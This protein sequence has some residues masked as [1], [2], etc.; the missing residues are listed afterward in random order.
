MVGT[1][2]P[3][4]MALPPQ[5]VDGRAKRSASESSRCNPFLPKISAFSKLSCTVWKIIWSTRPPE[6]QW[7]PHGVVTVAARASPRLPCLDFSCL[8]PRTT[9][10]SAVVLPLL[11]SP[12]SIGK[13]GGWGEGGA[14]RCSRPSFLPLTAR[15]LSPSF[16]ARQS[17]VTPFQGCLAGQ[18]MTM[19][20]DKPFKY[21]CAGTWKRRRRRTTWA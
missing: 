14:Q 6:L 13:G 19:G 8:R 18:S 4:T 17:A 10:A 9:W 15:E 2:V 11:S 21:G 1:K 12:S 5:P 16:A 20:H 7:V 3:S